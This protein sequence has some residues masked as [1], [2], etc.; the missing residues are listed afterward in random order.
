M[1]RLYIIFAGILLRY[2]TAIIWIDLLLQFSSIK[3]ASGV[4]Q[5]VELPR[6]LTHYKVILLTWLFAL[7]GFINKVVLKLFDILI[8]L[9]SHRCLYNRW[10]WLHALHHDVVHWVIY[11]SLG[12]GL[13]NHQS[14]RLPTS[15][16]CLLS[17]RNECFRVFNALSERIDGLNE[18]KF[19]MKVY[20]FWVLLFLVSLCFGFGKQTW[21]SVTWGI[22]NLI[23]YV[24]RPWLRLTL[25][26]TIFLSYL[27]SDFIWIGGEFFRVL[28][29]F[30]AY[31][32][33]IKIFNFLVGDW[34]VLIF[35]IGF[36]GLL[37]IR[38]FGLRFWWSTISSKFWSS[39]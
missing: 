23:Y 7:T 27:I 14:I 21:C 11:L 15:M 35:L 1:E 30:F 9:L 16:C 20:V 34:N 31:G 6:I 4:L 8:I 5:T 28:H 12:V 37:F 19:L 24:I 2:E 29:L 32:V 17:G 33:V 18:F 26:L 36:R 38:I 3:K 22:W 13:V 10:L 25:L 39:C